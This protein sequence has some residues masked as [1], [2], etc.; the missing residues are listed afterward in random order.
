MKLERFLA[1]RKKTLEEFLN[2]LRLNESPEQAREWFK[3]NGLDDAGVVLLQGRS[4]EKELTSSRRTNQ[5][6]SSNSDTVEED[7]IAETQQAQSPSSE[8]TSPKL[9]DTPLDRPKK[10]RKSSHEPSLESQ[11]TLVD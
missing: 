7:S 8:D 10:S 6:R 3:E 2:E 11:V 1:K 9:E 5:K 4:P